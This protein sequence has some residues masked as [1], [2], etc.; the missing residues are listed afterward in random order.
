MKAWLTDLRKTALVAAIG[1]AASAA[2]VAVNRRDVWTAFETT[3]IPGHWAIAFVLI[4]VAALAVF[5]IPLTFMITL[6]R[7]GGLL[8]IG[9][10]LRFL[11]LAAAVVN[12]APTVSYFVGWVRWFSAPTL[13]QSPTSSRSVIQGAIILISGITYILFLVAL[14]RHRA[15]ANETSAPSDRILG[16][17]AKIG[18]V[19]LGVILVGIV[20]AGIYTAT[21]WS[22]F[23]D[24]A[25]QQRRPL[26]SVSSMLLERFQ[27][28]LQQAAIFVPFYIV[29]KSLVV[30]PVTDEASRLDENG[31]DIPESPA[32]RM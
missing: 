24:L 29:R 8:R 9:N 11:A 13:F 20:A 25:L 22:Y 7:S 17:L 15:D 1:M 3:N 26:E 31:F 30:E 27:I 23:R 5:A 21:Q 4:G 19:V 32:D 16:H 6:Y 2:V 18:I 14:S 10:G 12:V 28:W